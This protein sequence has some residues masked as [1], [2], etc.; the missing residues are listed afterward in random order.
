MP[1]SGFEPA[2]PAIER[3]QTYALDRTATGI[4]TQRVLLT[5]NF[6]FRSVVLH[7]LQGRRGIE[8]CTYVVH[9]ALTICFFVNLIRHPLNYIKLSWKTIEM[10]TIK[11]DYLYCQLSHPSQI[12]PDIS[13]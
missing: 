13:K 1:S 9:L 5:Y 12:T 7:C 4:G 2:F 8:W 6:M 10:I 11:S 3:P